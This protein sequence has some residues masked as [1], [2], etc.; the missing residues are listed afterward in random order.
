ML[1]DQN[2]PNIIPG[3]EGLESILNA[4]GFGVGFNG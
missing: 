1:I 2:N 3:S 4:F